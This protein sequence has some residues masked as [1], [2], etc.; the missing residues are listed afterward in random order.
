MIGMITQLP[1][2]QKRVFSALAGGFVAAYGYDTLLPLPRVVHYGAAGL[3]V[4]VG[5]R[6]TDI[7]SGSQEVLMSAAAGVGGA[8]AAS[9]VLG[10]PVGSV[11]KFS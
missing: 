7:W 3:L 8:M 2:Q 4:D 9:L 1:C 10:K 6:S 11:L 5:C